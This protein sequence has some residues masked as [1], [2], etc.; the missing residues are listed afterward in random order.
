MKTQINTSAASKAFSAGLKTAFCMSGFSV[1]QRGFKLFMVLFLSCA[2]LFAKADSSVSS[3]ID[4]LGDKTVEAQALIKALDESVVEAQTYCS[5]EACPTAY[6]KTGYLSLAELEYGLVLIEKWG[7]TEEE[8]EAKKANVIADI[9]QKAA[10][11]V[12]AVQNM[13]SLRDRLQNAVNTAEQ[14]IA[15]LVEAQ[16]LSVQAGAPKSLENYEK[17]RAALS[18]LSQ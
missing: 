9:E 13:I 10:G 11:R 3:L 6:N 8:R 1:L 17:M 4:A 2:P 14:I 15:L 5:E 12:I 16:N 7:E 18:P